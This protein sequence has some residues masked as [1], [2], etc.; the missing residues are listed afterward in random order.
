MG[1]RGGLGL[2]TKKNFLAR[3]KSRNSFNSSNSFSD[4]DTNQ[5]KDVFRRPRLG[6]DG[7]NIITQ[8]K[9]A[10]KLLNSPPIKL[11]KSIRIQ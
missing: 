3:D 9:I 1:S 10:N 6:T 7:A 11:Q 4:E 5:V 2:A 8:E